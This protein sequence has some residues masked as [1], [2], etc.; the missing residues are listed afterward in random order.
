MRDNDGINYIQERQA[1]VEQL[2]AKGIQHPAVLSAIA[3]VPRHLFISEQQIMLAYEDH[4]LSIDCQQ[5]ISQPYIV[6]KMTE[7][8]IEKFIPKKVLEIGTGSGYQAAVLAT[9]GIQVY[10]IERHWHLHQQAI[11]ILK[12]YPNIVCHYG[13]GYLGFKEYAP[14]DGIIIT[15]AT[16]SMPDALKAQ[17]ALHSV[18]V[19]PERSLNQQ[20]LIRLQCLDRKWIREVFDSVIFVPM[21]SGISSEDE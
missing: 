9:L 19:Y 20:V 7:L 16:D 8:L 13:D 12:A 15:A 14:Y 18:C 11:K 4:A 2:K 10:T 6:A 5:T 21:L 3:T 1:L 17:M